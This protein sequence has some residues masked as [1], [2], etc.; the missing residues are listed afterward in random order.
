LNKKEKKAIEGKVHRAAAMLY[1]HCDSVRIFIT[2]HEG[3]EGTHAFTHGVG[4][5][6]AQK[7]QIDEWLKDETNGLGFDD[8]E[9]DD[10]EE[11]EQWQNS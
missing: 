10:E 11:E 7:G 4:N 1:E 6:Y 9:D 5:F 8:F 2:T 3:V